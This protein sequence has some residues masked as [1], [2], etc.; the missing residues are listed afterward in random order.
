MSHE[1]SMVGLTLKVVVI[2]ER[3]MDMIVEHQGEEAWY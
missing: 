1:V 3:E 2:S